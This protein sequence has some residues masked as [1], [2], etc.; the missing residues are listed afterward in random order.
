MHT[1]NFLFAFRLNL[2][3]IFRKVG[4]QFGIFNEFNDIKTNAQ[5]IA[6]DAATLPFDLAG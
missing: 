2:T 6:G 3:P 5:I 4:L 1:R